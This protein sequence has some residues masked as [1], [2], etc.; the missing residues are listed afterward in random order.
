MT[1]EQ[2]LIFIKP[3]GVKRQLVGQIL[4]R[5]EQ[6]G[7]Y[8]SELKKMTISSELSDT[9]YA[10]HIDKPF[11]PRL[12]QYVTSGPVVAAIIEGKN[13]IA[14]V[15]A[16]CGTTDPKEA[17]PGTIRGDFAVSLDANVIHSSDSVASAQRECENFFGS[18]I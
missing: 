1:V 14:I 17:L 13:A 9:H 15:R 12:K 6:R 7:L 18:T 5:F 3:D 10:E 11:Y 2:T 4:A 8:I 16:M